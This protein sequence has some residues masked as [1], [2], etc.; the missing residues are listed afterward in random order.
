MKSKNGSGFFASVKKR[1]ESLAW[2]YNIGVSH[3]P[4]SS[5]VFSST[6]TSAGI[7]FTNLLVGRKLFVQ[8]FILKFWTDLHKKQQA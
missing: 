7:D 1:L 5:P 3:Q 6:F 2:F 4:W 8:I